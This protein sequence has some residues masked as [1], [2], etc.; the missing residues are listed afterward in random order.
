MACSVGIFVSAWSAGPPT[1]AT[2][3]PAQFAGPAHH[4]IPALMSET[5][6]FYLTHDSD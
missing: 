6:V 1:G 3:K 2:R 4:G 5:N